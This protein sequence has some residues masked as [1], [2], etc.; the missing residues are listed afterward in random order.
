MNKLTNSF[1]YGLLSKISDAELEMI[2]RIEGLSLKELYGE[3]IA[4]N[5]DSGIQILVCPICT[6]KS[7]GNPLDSAW[8][9]VLDMEHIISHENSYAT[10]MRK[11]LDLDGISTER[12]HR[13]KLALIQNHL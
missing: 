13:V 9:G 3:W 1:F 6:L 10:M 8:V 12:F 7:I 11:L 4:R 2:G 5:S